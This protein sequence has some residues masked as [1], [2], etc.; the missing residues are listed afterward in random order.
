MLR[1]GYRLIGVHKR[2]QQFA[3]TAAQGFGDPALSTS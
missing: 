1:T 2:M 3:T